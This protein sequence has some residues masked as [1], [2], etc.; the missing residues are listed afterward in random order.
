MIQR[1]LGAKSMYHARM[2]IVLA[3]YMKILMPL[4]VVVPGLILFARYPEVL[5][6]PWPEVRPE[7]DC[8]FNRGIGF[9]PVN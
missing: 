3:G 6:L 9:Q 8:P 1:V 7:A 4:V 5:Q 2:G